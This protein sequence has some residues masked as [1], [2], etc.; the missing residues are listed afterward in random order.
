[1]VN[2]L[3]R[4]L[5]DKQTKALKAIENFVFEHGYAPTIRQLG[6]LLGIANPS[7]VFKHIIS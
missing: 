5:T 6:G 2:K 7:A 4:E 1:M 3:K